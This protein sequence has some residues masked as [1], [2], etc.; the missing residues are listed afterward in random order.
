MKTG[1]HNFHPARIS[2]KVKFAR[3][4]TANREAEKSRKKNKMETLDLKKQNW[5]LNK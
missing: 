5:S 2:G 4:L 3:A 1:G